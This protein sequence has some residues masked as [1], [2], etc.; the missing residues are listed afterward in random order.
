[1]PSFTSCHNPGRPAGHNAGC[2]HGRAS[3]ASP[4]HADGSYLF[5]VYNVVFVL[6]DATAQDLQ[7]DN[8]FRIKEA[9]E[10][11]ILG[12]G[13]G[14]YCAIGDALPEVLQQEYQSALV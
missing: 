2:S 14:L 5:A 3:S 13:E 8:A 1:M 10:P 6:H 12:S 9:A 4:R 7:G 11:E